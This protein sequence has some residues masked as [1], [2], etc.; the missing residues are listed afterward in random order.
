[1]K[2]VRVENVEKVKLSLEEAFLNLAGSEEK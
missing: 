2:G 1:M